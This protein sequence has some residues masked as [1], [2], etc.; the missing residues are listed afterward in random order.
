LDLANE[1]YIRKSE[2]AGYT[3]YSHYQQREKEAKREIY[4][5]YFN[6]FPQN[7]LD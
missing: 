6:S 2:A 1:I 3:H 7:H 4:Y 5:Y